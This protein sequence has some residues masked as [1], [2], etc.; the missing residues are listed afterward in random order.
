MP[1]QSFSAFLGLFAAAFVA[2]AQP[3]EIADDMGHRLRLERPAARIVS[4]A[5]HITELLF[6]VG[7]GDRI[8]GVV[9]H[10]DHPEAAKRIPVIGDNTAADLERI[11]ATRPDLILAWL[12][13]GS[14]KQ[15]ER[16]RSTGIPVYYSNPRTLEAIAREGEKL[17]LLAGT[18]RE[19]ETWVAQYRARRER[20]LSLYATRIK[21]LVFYQMWA[22]PLYTL[23]REHFV[24]D[25]LSTCGATNV[26]ASLPLVAP[27]V[28]TEAVLN[29]NPQAIIGAIPAEELKSQWGRWKEIDAVRFGNIYSVDADL[30][31]RSGPRAII[32]AEIVCEQIDQARRRLA[33][34]RPAPDAGKRLP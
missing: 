12:H 7:A 13:A 18:S 10:S 22:R 2:A 3:V 8:V 34:P 27:V 21:V 24:N 16:L 33:R 29:A 23:N 4:F 11:V 25:V 31:H 9:R 14:M 30:I 28:N 5:P 20:L 32:G 1:W 15:L 17:A 6:A 19:A 26:F